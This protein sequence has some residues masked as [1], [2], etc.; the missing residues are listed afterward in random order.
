MYVS[1]KSLKHGAQ[2][3]AGVRKPTFKHIRNA[4]WRHERLFVASKLSDLADAI[5]VGVQNSESL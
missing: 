5:D 1:E 4:I 3:S 2:W